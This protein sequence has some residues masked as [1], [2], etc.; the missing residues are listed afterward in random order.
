MEF[1]ARVPSMQLVECATKHMCF[2][3]ELFEP[4][5]EWAAMSAYRDTMV[6]LQSFVEEI[7]SRERCP[8][9]HLGIYIDQQGACLLA[10][11]K[12]EMQLCHARS[13]LSTL[14]QPL[15]TYEKG[16]RV[17]SRKRMEKSIR[18]LDA[19][20]KIRL[21][22]WKTVAQLRPPFPKAPKPE[23][24]TP[25]HT[26]RKEFFAACESSES[27]DDGPPL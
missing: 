21:D 12:V 17:T 25:P 13:G 20:D 19:L 9:A 4:R 2:Y 11:A 6:A 24:P 15:D 1:L 18:P 5:P 14:L 8:F 3:A 23:K 26:T 27:E 22:E 7:A 16:A 10:T